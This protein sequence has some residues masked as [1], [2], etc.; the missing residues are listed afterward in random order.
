MLTRALLASL[1][2]YAAAPVAHA[3]PLP[4]KDTA[5]V[6]IVEFADFQCPFSERAT[7]TIAELKK[8]YGAKLTFRWMNNPLA[9]HVRARAAAIAV[10]AARLQGKFDAMHAKLFANQRALEDADIRRYAKA[11]GLNLAKFDAALADAKIAAL[12][13]RDM[14]IA[15]ALGANGTPSFFVNGKLLAGAQP[16]AAFSVLID[17]EV[18][19]AGAEAGAAWRETRA[20]VNNE[21]F[22][23]Y[24]FKNEPAPDAAPPRDPSGPTTTAELEG[25][26]IAIDTKSAPVVGAPGAKTEITVFADLQCPFSARAVPMLEQLVAKKNGAVALRFKHMPLGF[27]KMAG[28][29]GEAVACAAE[30]GKAW[31]LID[32]IYGNQKD[33]APETLTAWEKAAGLDQKALDA[34]LAAGRGKA[35][36]DA[37]LQQAR[38]AHVVG[39]PTLFVNGLRVS[40]WGAPNLEALIDSAPAR[41]TP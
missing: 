24:V 6:E 27:H 34:C 16:A 20:G 39:T 5:V 32:A 12:V 18:A 30:Q 14:K 19:A 25:P 17:E 37:D 23:R 31:A 15:Q 28:P 36:V 26:A 41:P 35:V 13:D 10:E 1:V 8:T 3:K 9:F 2:L 38:D 7:A 21:A 11:I 33:L 22:A 4:V 29:A 40:A